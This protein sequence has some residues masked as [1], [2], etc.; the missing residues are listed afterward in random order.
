[1]PVSCFR[2]RPQSH[3]RLLR[4]FT[5]DDNL[6]P[7]PHFSRRAQFWRGRQRFPVAHSGAFV[8]GLFCAAPVAC[9]SDVRAA[10]HGDS[11][12]VAMR[13][14]RGDEASLPCLPNVVGQSHDSLRR[15]DRDRG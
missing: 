11:C 15:R 1:M 3:V 14:D 10:F 4:A 8:N 7:C 13:F 9:L 5:F 6:L 2:I 12:G